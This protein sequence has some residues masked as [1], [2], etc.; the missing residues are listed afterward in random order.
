MLPIIWHSE[1]G[2][3]IEWIKNNRGFLLLLQNSFISLDKVCQRS[4]IPFLLW[5]TNP[6]SRILHCP[7]THTSAGTSTLRGSR[8]PLVDVASFRFCTLDTNFTRS[9]SSNVKVW[10]M[11][12]SS[13][14]V[15]IFF[16]PRESKEQ[17]WQAA[18]VYILLSPLSPANFTVMYINTMKKSQ[19]NMISSQSWACS[20]RFCWIKKCPLW[21]KARVGYSERI[22]LKQVYYQGWNRSPAQVGCM[23]QALGPGALVK[24]RG[25]GWRG[26]WEGGSGWG[27]HVNPWLFH[28]NVWQ[29]SLQKKK[30]TYSK[31]TFHGAIEGSRFCKS[32]CICLVWN[33]CLYICQWD[34]TDPSLGSFLEPL[35]SRPMPLNGTEWEMEAHTIQYG[36]L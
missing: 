24:P 20:C 8:L 9:I 18:G 21:E 14:E 33:I 35:Y 10:N 4:T 25:S 32:Q 27:T 30:K 31:V 12:T 7:R 19:S 15:F 11:Y 5:L 36:R 3:T 28:S 16:L 17:P 23:R 22:A 34:V 13:E 1:K 26:R 6:L 29:N 2:K